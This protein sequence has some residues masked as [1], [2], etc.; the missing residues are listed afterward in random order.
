MFS[1]VKKIKSE[2]KRLSGIQDLERRLDIVQQSL[3]RI[4]SRQLQSMKTQLEFNDYEF[5][6]FSQ[7]GEDGLIDFLVNQLP[8]EKKIFVEFGVENYLESNTRLL[9]QKHSWSGLVLDGNQENINEILKSDIYWRSKL[10]AVC[11]FITAENINQLLEENG[12]TGEIGL[13]SIDID[14]N[15][16]WVWKEITV[17]SPIIVVLEYNYRF[18]K[19]G[20]YTIPYDPNFYRE[21]SP[22]RTLFGASLK[23]FEELGEKKG[24]KLL[25]TNKAGLNAF[26]IREDWLIKGNLTP[27]KAE[28]A[29]REGVFK[30]YILENGIIRFFESSE[31]ELKYFETLPKMKL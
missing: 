10:K 6:I 20:A 26:F 5:R 15:D 27:I 24:Y 11:A 25:G 7:W 13:L 22:H 30:D 17:I 28:E 14:G 21:K 16:Y 31:E 23:A 18:G 12:L 9:L 29:F 8:I 2:I 1:I 19:E 4:E 3:A